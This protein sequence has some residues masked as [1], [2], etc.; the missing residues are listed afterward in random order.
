MAKKEGKSG[1]EMSVEERLE[2]IKRNTEEI[3]TVDA[4][5]EV[6]SKKKPRVYCGY[7][8]N[9]PMHLGHFV[10]VT[11]LLDLQKAGF[12]IV[13]LLADVHAMLNRKGSESEI[14]KEVD[15]WKNEKLFFVVL[16]IF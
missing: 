1:K 15:N 3:I 7:E 5:K 2:L 8:P 14:N 11:K 4:L 10:T 6:L 13:I 9:G 16:D 12:E